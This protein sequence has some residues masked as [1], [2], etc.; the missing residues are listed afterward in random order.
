MNLDDGADSASLYT[1][2]TR[3]SSSTEVAATASG[4]PALLA[5]IAKWMKQCLVAHPGRLAALGHRVRRRRQLS[6][7]PSLGSEDREQ[8]TWATLTRECRRATRLGTSV[9]VFALDVGERPT[10]EQAVLTLSSTVRET[11]LVVLGPVPHSVIAI[12]VIQDLA[13]APST[14]HRLSKTLHGVDIDIARSG[15]AVFPNDHA[16]PAEL[17]NLAFGRL[18]PVDDETASSNSTTPPDGTEVGP[19]TSPSES[20]AKR[21]PLG[22]ALWRVFEFTLASAALMLSLPVIG[23]AALAVRLN[24]HGPAMFVQARS[25]LDGRPFKLYKLRSMTLNAEDRL[26]EVAELN[27]IEG[28]FKSSKDPRVTRIGRTLRRTSIDE[29][30]QL[31]NVLRGEMA[32]VGPRPSSNLIDRHLPWELERL[33][34]KPGLTGL[35]QVRHRGQLSFNDR[36]RLDIQYARERSVSLDLKI[37]ALTVP[38][39][40]SARGRH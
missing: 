5:P 4:S 33:T 23:A 14:L 28:T 38:A 20:D 35:W 37:L 39:V 27:E 26:E 25:G 21:P 12:L 15:S 2:A 22:A 13:A 9:A 24:D 17:V 19:A 36:A 40:L 7:V 11:D 10:A 32:L 18:A 6:S 16:T 30:P 3:G 29:L 31:W 1:T 34:V 8:M